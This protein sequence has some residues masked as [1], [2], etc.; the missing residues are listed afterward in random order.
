MNRVWI[1]DNNSKPSDEKPCTVATAKWKMHSMLLRCGFTMCKNPSEKN[2]DLML[3]WTLACHVS[4]EGALVAFWETVAEGW[5]NSIVLELVQ[6]PR[7]RYYHIIIIGS[8]L[9]SRE[10]GRFLLL[11][12]SFYRGYQIGFLRHVS[13]PKFYLNPVTLV[14]VFS[15]LPSH[16][17]CMLSIPNLAPILL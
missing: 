3:L 5:G 12:S 9:T 17:Q 11:Y 10:E 6:I 7:D 13:Q 8:F 2:N 4:R 1:K 15:I 14:V 16:T